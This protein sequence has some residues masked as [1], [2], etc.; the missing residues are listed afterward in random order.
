MSTPKN[1][2]VLPTPKIK[3]SQLGPRFVIA[4][5][6]SVIKPLNKNIIAAFKL[7]NKFV[8]KYCNKNKFYCG[9]NLSWVI[10]NNELEIYILNKLVIEKQLRPAQLTIFWHYIPTQSMMNYLKH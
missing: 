9:V 5:K 10:Q 7:L 4:S 3:K 1:N 6:Q 8:K 2:K